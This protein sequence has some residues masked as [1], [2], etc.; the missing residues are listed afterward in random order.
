LPFVFPR[1]SSNKFFQACFML[2]SCGSHVDRQSIPHRV[3]TQG[4][5]LDGLQLD[6]LQL[7]LCELAG[8]RAQASVVHRFS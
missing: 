7:E 3:V 5:P 1:A 2:A 6:G 4:M 8:L